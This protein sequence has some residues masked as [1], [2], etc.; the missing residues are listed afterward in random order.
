MNIVIHIEAATAAE[1]QAAIRELWMGTTPVISLAEEIKPAEEVKEPVIEKP[2]RS[3]K[4]VE[5]K[6]A[7]KT[8][9]PT[10]EAAPDPEPE[11]EPEPTPEPEPEAPKLT[12]E[13]VRE[14]L[15]DLSRSGK[16]PEVKALIATFGVN[17][18]TDVPADKYPKVM[19]A[20]EALG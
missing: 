16:T 2:S 14:K 19:A 17:R 12:L 1:A 13:V 8:P 7:E 4:H 11:P 3:R 9:E 15:A 5:P 18:L 10:Q 20:A 6:Q